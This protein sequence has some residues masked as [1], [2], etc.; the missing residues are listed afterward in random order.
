MEGEVSPEVK[1]DEKLVQEVA[2][3]EVVVIDK[4]DLELV[5]TACSE[6]YKIFHEAFENATIKAGRYLIKEF[7]ADSIERARKN[8]SPKKETLNQ[9]IL[10]LHRISTATP[11]RSWIYQS[12]NLVVQE[13]DLKGMEKYEKLS[14]S[15]KNILLSVKDLNIK[16][17][18][19]DEIVEKSLSV[20]GFEKRKIELL[21]VEPGKKGL[22][23]LLNRH[24]DI[25]KKDVK[26]ALSFDELKKEQPKK[27]K[28]I[29]NK[30]KK[31]IE[32]LT[33]KIKKYQ[34]NIYEY[35]QTIKKY[36]KL[37]KV[38]EEALKDKASFKKR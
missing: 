5:E 6:I 3:T 18:L 27:L 19:I 4:V 21:A 20:H 16:K 22:I 31:K 38:A 7:Y 30:A 12:I 25:S 2:S 1:A 36:K 13:H 29:K 26:T 34:E 9:L 11:S 32:E 35:R 8:N 17:R 15:H 37:S 28:A 23:T 24:E 14:L 10:K 33:E